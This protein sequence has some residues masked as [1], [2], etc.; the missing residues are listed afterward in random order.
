MLSLRVNWYI[1]SPIGYR[2]CQPI[3]GL[4]WFRVI[5]GRTLSPATLFHWQHGGFSAKSIVLVHLSNSRSEQ[6]KQYFQHANKKFTY[7][8]ENAFKLTKSNGK[9]RYKYTHTYSTHTNIRIWRSRGTADCWIWSW[10]WTC[11]IG[12]APCAVK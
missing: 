10:S 6:R 1:W 7:K 5:P 4:Q 8:C 11:Q 12:A 3:R 2:I 9:C